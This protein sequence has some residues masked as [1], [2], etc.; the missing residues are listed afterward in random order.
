MSRKALILIFFSVLICGSF[1]AGYLY[2]QQSPKDKS[3]GGRKILYYADPLNPGFKSDKPGI[4][5][6]GIP[7]EPVYSVGSG[8]DSNSSMPCFTT[9]A[10]QILPCILKRVSEP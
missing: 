4:A 9:A 6:T 2:N 7:L 1:L 3:S 8:I 5:P 10:P